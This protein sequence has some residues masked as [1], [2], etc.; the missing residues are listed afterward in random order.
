MV[1][2]STKDQAVSEGLRKADGTEER[3]ALAEL[4][5][6]R[7]D[8]LVAAGQSDSALSCFDATRQTAQVQGARMLEMRAARSCARLLADR[9]GRG[10]AIDLLAQIYSWF[11]EG[12]D[13]KDLNEARGLPE[14]LGEELA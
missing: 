4:Q 1:R 8:L 12:F 2:G 11:T 9:G 13:T 3:F 7:A 5:R 14:E 6:L 10:A